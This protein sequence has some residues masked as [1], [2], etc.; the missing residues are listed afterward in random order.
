MKQAHIKR[1]EEKKNSPNLSETTS[2]Q[3]GH[4]QRPRRYRS[5]KQ[6]SLKAYLRTRVDT[7]RSLCLMHVTP[8]HSCNIHAFVIF[9][10][11]VFS[12][13][14][15]TDTG[16]GIAPSQGEMRKIFPVFESRSTDYLRPCRRRT[17]PRSRSLAAVY[18]SKV[19]LHRYTIHMYAFSSCYVSYRSELALSEK[20][21]LNEYMRMVILLNGFA[22]LGYFGIHFF[23]SSFPCSG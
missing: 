2:E 13:L 8:M 18:V 10:L 3:Q 14:R 21:F 22:L 5:I 1:R 6:P 12:A 17:S 11:F 15:Y 7:N 19:H 4:S 23:L 20:V 9:C 16:R